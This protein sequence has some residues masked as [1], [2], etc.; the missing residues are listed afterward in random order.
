[1]V[2]GERRERE[3]ERLSFLIPTA[4]GSQANKNNT[5]ERD[6]EEIM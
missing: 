5:R 3:V 6:K 1:M 2:W 4:D